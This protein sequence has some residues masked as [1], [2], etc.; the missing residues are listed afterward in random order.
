MSRYRRD[1]QV[2]VKA[3]RRGSSSSNANPRWRVETTGGQFYWTEP[4]AAVGY[5]MDNYS[6]TYVYKGGKK[7]DIYCTVTLTLNEYGH[8]VHVTGPDAMDLRARAEGWSQ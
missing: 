4:D 5:G 1:I 3:V 8:I 7:K 2:T 6:P